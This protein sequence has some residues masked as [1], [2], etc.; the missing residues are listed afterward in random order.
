MKEKILVILLMLCVFSLFAEISIVKVWEEACGMVLDPD[1]DPD[2]IVA[3]DW[4]RGMSVYDDYLIVVRGGDPADP[5]DG[6]GPAINFFSIDDGQ[7][8]EDLS[9]STTGVQKDGRYGLNRAVFADDGAL[10]ASNLVV[11]AEG[12]HPVLNGDFILWRWEDIDADPEEIFRWDGTPQR[13]RLGDGLSVR[14]T[15]ED[16][17]ILVVGN[18]A[19]SRPLVVEKDGGDWVGN[20]ADNPVHAITCY[21]NEDGTFWAVRYSSGVPL[22]KF[23]ADGTPI[24][25][26]S[27]GFEGV[28]DPNAIPGFLIDEEDNVIYTIGLVGE[29]RKIVAWSMGGVP[30]AE[31]EVFEH[32]A[33]VITGT[34]YNGTAALSF[35]DNRNVYV[36]L[37]RNGVARFDIEMITSAS[38]WT[39]FH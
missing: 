37:E 35:D 3:S 39:L 10:Y 5:E 12:E 30:F 33:A 13:L 1:D 23:E 27:I 17:R 7:P 8:R 18:H 9:I 2:E 14:G 6:E 22:Q 26:Q 25:G 24:D 32:E 11:Q 34:W 20:F 31:S 38:T 19:D 28:Y 36:L 21:L 29:N 4:F 15:G 16:T